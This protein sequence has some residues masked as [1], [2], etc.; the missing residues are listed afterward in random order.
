MVY[1][2]YIYIDAVISNVLSTF[3][4]IKSNIKFMGST[5]RTAKALP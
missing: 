5:D 4:L 2:Q 3:G 1:W